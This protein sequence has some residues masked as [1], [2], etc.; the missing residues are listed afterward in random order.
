MLAD[1]TLELLEEI[2]LSSPSPRRI[3]AAIVVMAE[4]TEHPDVEQISRRLDVALSCDLIQ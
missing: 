1:P 3:A 2:E 4:A